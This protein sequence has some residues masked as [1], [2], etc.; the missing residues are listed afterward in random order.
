M[1]MQ[2]SFSASADLV[3]L[4][5]PQS[6]FTFLKDHLNKFINLRNFYPTRIEFNDYI[7]LQGFCEDTHGLSDTL[8][9]V[10][11][12]R[13]YEIFQALLDKRLEAELS[14]VN[15]KGAP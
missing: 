14:G 2:R 12:T 15:A 4:R 9:S 7:F 8:L 1:S 5:N 11:P 13:S 10:L 6:R 3:T